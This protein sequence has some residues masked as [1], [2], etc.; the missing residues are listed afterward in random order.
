VPQ[1]GE[2]LRV[3]TTLSRPPK[4]KIVLFVGTEQSLF[5]WFN[6]ERRQRPAQ[7]PVAAQ[8]A[9]G[10]TRDCFLDCGRVTVFPSEELARATRCGRASAA[11]L[12]RVADEIEARASSLVTAHRR[13]IAAALRAAH[14]PPDTFR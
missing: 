7:L 1:I 6:T 5:L 12:A 10:I 2:V 13:A 4:E 8:E 9:P 14:T 3:Y 11:F